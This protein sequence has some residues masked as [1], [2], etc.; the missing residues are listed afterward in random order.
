MSNIGDRGYIGPQTTIG[1]F[2]PLVKDKIHNPH[3]TLLALFL[4]AVHEEFGELDSLKAIKS[5]S[6]HLRRYLPLN[7]TMLQ[8]GGEFKADSLRFNDA[9]M[10]VRDFD[11]LF[12]R[13][14]HE[15]Q[16]PEISRAAGLAAKTTNTIIEPWPMRLKK[17]ALHRL[18]LTSF[19]RLV[20][21]GPRGMSNGRDYPECSFVHHL[22]RSIRTR[23]YM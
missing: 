10:M 23:I 8:S 15:C 16:F 20:T 6:D 9:R 18:S 1:T 22:E 4:N 11:A 12:H 5:E 13:F 2:G 7:P 14:M 17:R 19:L 21:W 3:A